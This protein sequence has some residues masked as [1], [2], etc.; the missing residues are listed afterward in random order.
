MRK[1]L[2]YLFVFSAFLYGRVAFAQRADTVIVHRDV[3]QQIQ[4]VVD[5]LA[6]KLAVPAQQLFAVLVRQ[7]IVEAYASVAWALFCVV[8]PS[9]WWTAGKGW[10]SDKA[11]EFYSGTN[12]YHSNP[13]GR[14][15][16]FGI[17]WAITTICTIGFFGALSSAITTGM[18][19]QY[20]AIHEIL[21]AI[22]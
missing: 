5:H 16:Y 11:G 6:S 13:S 17:G 19:P 9:I 3:G 8:I 7:G 12:G 20:F 2:S 4:D 21:S 15:V 22:R 14:S 18:N 10:C 1:L